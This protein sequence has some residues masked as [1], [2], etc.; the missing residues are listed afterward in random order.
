[1][2]RI[3]FTLQFMSF[4]IALLGTN[5]IYAQCEP[6]TY[7]TTADGKSVIYTCPGD[8]NADEYTF[9]N[10]A[11][12]DANYAYAIT[13]DNNIIIGVNPTG[14]QDFE[15]AGV[16]N[17]RVWGFSYTGEI[18]AEAGDNVFS[19]FFSSGCWGISRN[20]VNIVRD[21]PDGGNVFMPSGETSK[22]VCTTDGYDNVI[23]FRHSTNS[24][25][26]YRYVITDDN[27]NIL[28][29]P[30][31]NS[32]NFEGVP[33]GICRVWG[34]SYTGTVTAQVGDN[35]TNTSLTDD[36][37]DLSDNFIEVIRTDVDGG[38]VSGTDNETIYNIC[39]G[40]G[41][42][43]EITF[44]HDNNSDSFYGYII[45][46]DNNHVL[47]LPIGN[48]ANFEGAPAGVCRVWGISYTGD[49][50][51]YTGDL[52][53]D[54]AL[55]TDCF[56]LSENYIEIIREDCIDMG[57]MVEG[58]AIFPVG[59]TMV[60][61]AVIANRASGTISVINADMN[62]VM[63]SYPMPNGGQPMY[64]VHNKNNNTVL[65]GD[66]FGTVA[67]FDG[68]TYDYLGS[69]TAGFGV[70]HMW[71]SPDN[72]QLWVN[73]EI[74]K[75]ISV[76]HPSTLETITTF[77][78]PSDLDA[79]GFKPH[80]VIVD[81]SN[82]Y[83][84]VTMI[85]SAEVNYVVKYDAQTFQEV[86]RA[87]VGGD[88]HVSLTGMNNM[89]Y[90][91]CQASDELY[92]LNRNDLSEETILSVP[93]A[94]GLGMNA[95]GTYLYIGNIA[96]SGTDATYTLDVMTNTLVGEGIDAP[97]A[98]PHN[99]AVSNND[100]QLFLTHSGGSSDKVSVYNLAPTPTL[101]AELTTG[102]N[103]F[104]L[105]A[106]SY[107]STEIDICAG[108]GQSDAFDV[109]LTGNTG[110]SSWV[111][112]DADGTILGLPPGPPFDLEGAGAGVCLIWHLSY[113]DMVA[114]LEVG[115]NALTD[116]DGCYALSNPITVNRTGVDGG[117]VSMPSGDTER[118]ICAEDGV[119]D[120]VMFTHNN[121]SDANYQYVITDENNTILG[122]PPSNSLDFDGAGVG[123]CRVWGLS[124]TGMITAQVGDDAAAVALTDACF[125]LSDNFIT[126]IRDVPHGGTVSTDAGETDVTIVAGDGNAD[127]IFFAHADAS[128]SNYQYVVTDENN[129]ILGLPGN[130]L[131]FEGAGVGICRVWGLSYTGSLIAEVGDDAAA[132]ALSDDC[133][134]LSAN[135][136]TVNRVASLIEDTPGFQA[137]TISAI[138]QSKVSIYPN[139][140]QNTSNLEFYLD[141]TQSL[142]IQ[143][144]T[145]NGQVLVQEKLNGVRGFNQYSINASSW[146]NGVYFIQVRSNNSVIVQN[147]LT[148]VGY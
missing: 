140:T 39:V 102:L 96:D 113:E 135:F 89:L 23:Q 57:C 121:S 112:T 41:Q 52:I 90:V 77:P 32:L 111:I 122:L 131:D 64:A 79:D 114:G 91:A 119:E 146:Q 48:M 93:N 65:V 144:I 81:P 47:A 8:E 118:Y 62:T 18:L 137:I 2:K 78:I 44:N 110:N 45:T 132:V 94:H 55:S 53:T 25:A 71:I 130:S 21:N 20:F 51:I 27:N 19:T 26:A 59:T 58:G 147:R 72:Q 74:D 14:V 99:Y 95:A 36:C 80:D 15:G 69:A 141:Q 16:G 6:A 54:K 30:P 125:D 129:T 82:A 33:A 66:Y 37:F 73:N 127:E 76:I 70:F 116:L 10:D 75:T 139:P 101:V 22:E 104:G 46:D 84:Y 115:N 63:N 100:A 85:S 42:A 17:C 50:T 49:L 68:I 67:A 29:L 28:G 109:E 88:P 86:G 108:D 9:T 38:L 34:L 134:D 103:P 123:I 98:V 12:A 56:D 1:M 5:S 24:N 60:N 145:I 126:I 124:Y 107:A 106:Y 133:F 3:S 13:D 61:R 97:F 138:D 7:V 87:A 117:T 148:K 136:I 35:A 143:I 105:V 128:N 120:I 4:L 83:A 92:V 43:D 31:G 11:T 142:D 40:D